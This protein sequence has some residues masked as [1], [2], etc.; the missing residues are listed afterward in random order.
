ML[1]PPYRIRKGRPADFESLQDVE[2]AAG[3]MFADVG[4]GEATA[5][6][7]TSIE[8]FTECEKTGLLWVAVD[9]D[10]AP[11]GFAFVEIVDGQTHLDELSV[12]PG[13]GRRGIGAALVQTV[14]DW[15]RSNGYAAVTL[16]TFRE[17]PWNMPFY[18]RLGFR[19]LT[20]AELTPELREVVAAE[21]RRGL[22]PEKRLVMRYDTAPPSG[23]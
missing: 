10:D 17:V 2:L 18:E 23:E 3:E 5:G 1:P 14:I 13:H 8:D 12:H 15:A 21:T 11:I 7:A 16:T 4:L 9:G 6:D 19:G 20:D 22:P